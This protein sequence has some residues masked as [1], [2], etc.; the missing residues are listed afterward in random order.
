MPNKVQRERAIKRTSDREG[1]REIQREIQR[2]ERFEREKMM[3]R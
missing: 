2:G 1:S 3:N